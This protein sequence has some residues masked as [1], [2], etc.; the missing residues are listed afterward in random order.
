MIVNKT[1]A[2][3]PFMPSCITIIRKISISNRWSCSIVK[4]KVASVS[5]LTTYNA[6]AVTSTIITTIIITII[7]TVDFQHRADIV[8]VAAGVV[9]VMAIGSIVT[10][11]AGVVTAIAIGSVPSVSRKRKGSWVG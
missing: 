8:T 10:V 2:A 5:T 3:C 9:T 1:N 4:R 11:A 7:F 6:I